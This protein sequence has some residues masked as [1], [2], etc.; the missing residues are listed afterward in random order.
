MRV[1]WPMVGAL[2]KRPGNTDWEYMLHVPGTAAFWWC[3]PHVLDP[4]A[5][6]GPVPTAAIVGK[7]YTIVDIP[8][9]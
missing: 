5:P 6:T 4:E 3:G 8:P 7:T 2:A 1:V 9:S